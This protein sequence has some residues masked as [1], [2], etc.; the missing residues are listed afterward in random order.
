MNTDGNLAALRQYERNIDRLEVNL[1]YV[2]GTYKDEL[3]SLEENI[4]NIFD[5]I[6]AIR[7]RIADSRDEQGLNNDEEVIDD[8]IGSAIGDD[9]NVKMIENGVWETL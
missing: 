6:G 2:K 3:E 7:S 4:T 5:E 9:S 8:V 1:E